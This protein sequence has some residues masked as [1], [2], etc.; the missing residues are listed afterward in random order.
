MNAHG[1]VKIPTR[2]L[3]GVIAST[4]ELRLASRMRAPPD[5][6]ELRLDH[7]PNLQESQLSRL[8]RP[9]ILTA[10]HPAEGGQKLR[11]SRNDL[12]HQFLPHAKFLDVELRSIRELRK[13]WDEAGQL[14]LGRICSLHDFKGTPDLPVLRRQLLRARKAGADVFKLV[15]RADTLRDLLTLFEFLWTQISVVP[16]CVMAVGK[17]GQISRLLF[18]EAGSVFIYAPL[19]HTLYEGQ[20]TLEQLR[21]QGISRRKIR[22]RANS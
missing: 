8:R 12:L 15:T 5:L 6:F 11:Y 10:R 9:L 19:R 14:G 1:R 7:L 2:A 16:I 17:F 13:V 22:P 20:L 18:L 4:D 21:R 3:V